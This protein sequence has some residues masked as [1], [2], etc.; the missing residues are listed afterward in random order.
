M[1]KQ[2]SK[3][4]KAFDEG[5]KAFSDGKQ[6]NECPYSRGKPSSMERENYREWNRGHHYAYCKK[7]GWCE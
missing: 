4:H 5:I 3:N 1:V 2:M 6:Y 7:Q